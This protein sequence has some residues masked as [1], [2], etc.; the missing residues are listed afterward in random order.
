M[1]SVNHPQTEGNRR[2]AVLF[3]K[4]KK[5]VQIIN[6]CE[7]HYQRIRLNGLSGLSELP[8]EFYRSLNF[9]N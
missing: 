4:E 8:G 3:K 9:F 2:P 6:Q 7:W 1:V 5:K